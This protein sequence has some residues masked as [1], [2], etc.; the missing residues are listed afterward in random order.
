MNADQANAT[1]GHW[2]YSMHFQTENHEAE[3]RL[4]LWK[5]ENR[6]TLPYAVIALC[7]HGVDF[8]HKAYLSQL[9]C[10]NDAPCGS[11]GDRQKRK[12]HLQGRAEKTPV[13]L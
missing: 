6:H 3:S 1:L 4:Y 8:Y 13:R 5:G 12:I 7:N 2:T 9:V 10:R 11:R